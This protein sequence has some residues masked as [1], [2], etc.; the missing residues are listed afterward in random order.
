MNSLVWSDL[1]K[2]SFALFSVTGGAHPD[3]AVLTLLRQRALFPLID[4]ARWTD[5]SHAQLPFMLLGRTIGL[6][7]A[8]VDSA[9]TRDDRDAVIAPAE[10]LARRE[11]ATGHR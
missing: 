3:T 5:P 6:S 4:M 2:G 9:W 11:D 1:N 7:P 8:A 10:Q